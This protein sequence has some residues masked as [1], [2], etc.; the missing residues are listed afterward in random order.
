[1]SGGVNAAAVPEVISENGYDVHSAGAERDVAGRWRCTRMIRREA[2]RFGREL[3]EMLEA[4][5]GDF[6]VS[7]IAGCGAQ[8]K[9]LGHVVGGETAEEVARKVRDVTE[10]LSE[11]GIRPPTGRVERVVTYHDPC[12]LVHAHKRIELRRRVICWGWCRD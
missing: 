7:P 2:R 9:E 1:M 10:F 8:L 3:V 11:I 6:F 4:K 5:G 12:H